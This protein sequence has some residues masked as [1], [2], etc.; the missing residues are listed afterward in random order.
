MKDQFKKYI[1]ILDQLHSTGGITFK[2]LAD[3][4]ERASINDR[5][6]V[7]AKRTFDDYRRAIE[8][9]FGIRILCDA[10]RDYKYRIENI[11]S[12][13]KN[14]VK[15]W[16]LSSFAVN[17][18]LQGSRSL[19]ERIVYEDIP[20]GNDYLLDVVKAMQNNKMIRVSYDNFFENSV[21]NLL[22]A[23]YCVKVFRQRWYVIGKAFR[24]R[25]IWRWALDRFVNMEV[26]EQK[27]RMPKDFC[28]D[29]YFFDAFG[30]IV[31]E[32]ECPVETIR[33]KAYKA[34]HRDEYLRHLPLHHSQREIESNSEYS[35]FEVCLRPAYDFC[36]ELL[37]YGEEIEVLSPQYVRD[38]MAE[39]IRKMAEMYKN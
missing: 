29:L 19:S 31:D 1:W 2:K 10:S 11:Q 32:D 23:P 15:Q 39:R 5:N 21:Q 20:S 27:F 36:Q 37:S 25:T 14:H 8:E 9:T 33:F 28:A 35:I 17:N 4:W 18:I 12:L 34:N 24:Q 22:I 13:S 26:A 3:E 16:L 38:Y 7:L 6:T 30:V